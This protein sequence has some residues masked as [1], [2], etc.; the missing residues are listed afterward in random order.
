MIVYKNVFYR[1][2]FL[3]DY[4]CLLHKNVLQI[5]RVVNT[6]QFVRHFIFYI[7]I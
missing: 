3:S 4:N 7:K 5:A 1:Y 6:R 2:I